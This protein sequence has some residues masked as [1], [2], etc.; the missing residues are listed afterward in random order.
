MVFHLTAI[1]FRSFPW[2]HCNNAVGSLAVS[3]YLG[4]LD[5]MQIEDSIHLTPYNNRMHHLTNL[6]LPLDL[7]IS[8]NN[9]YSAGSTWGSRERGWAR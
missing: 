6:S 5:D 7:P 3:R 8:T 2:I 9:I 4:F 1:L